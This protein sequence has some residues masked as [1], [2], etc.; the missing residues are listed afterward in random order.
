MAEAI[1]VAISITIPVSIT[2]TL[3]ETL[4]E[5]NYTSPGVPTIPT[6]ILTEPSEAPPSEG[7]SSPNT[8]GP[9]GPLANPAGP[10]GSGENPP[11]NSNGPNGPGENPSGSLQRIYPNGRWIR[12]PAFCN[13]FHADAANFRVSPSLHVSAIKGIVLVGNRVFLTG[14]RR[15]DIDGNGIIWYEAFNELPLESSEENVALNI[16]SANQEGWIADC[17]VE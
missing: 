16:L 5:F 1:R 12:I 8:P 10:N 2:L 17:F 7:P 13:G 4:A 15:T 14:E 9:T 6:G 11:A 3:F